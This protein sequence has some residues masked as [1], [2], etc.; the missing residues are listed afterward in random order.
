[1][2]KYVWT[3]DGKNAIDLKWNSSDTLKL[4]YLKDY[5]I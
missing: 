4:Y 1:M 5:I 3:K 2:A